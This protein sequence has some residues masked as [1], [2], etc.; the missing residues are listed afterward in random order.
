MLD[1]FVMI[2]TLSESGNKVRATVNGKEFLITEWVPHILKGLP[3]GEVIIKLELIDAQGNLIA[4]PFN[5]VNRTVVLKYTYFCKRK[6]KY[7]SKN[8]R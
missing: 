6:T 3:K 4:G 5:E 1:F 8:C 2:T 7:E